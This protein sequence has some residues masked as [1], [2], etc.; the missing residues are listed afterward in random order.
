MLKDSFDV[1]GSIKNMRKIIKDLQSMSRNK[2]FKNDKAIR[3]LF[4]AL[5]SFLKRFINWVKSFFI[6]PEYPPRPKL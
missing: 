4:D 2:I 3:K 1:D 6:A 5:I